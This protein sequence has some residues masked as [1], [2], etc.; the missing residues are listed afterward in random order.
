ML[1]KVPTN[2]KLIGRGGNLP[3]MCS[4][5]KCYPE[6]MFHLFF[7][8]RFAFGLWCWLATSLDL[9]IQF[10]SLEDIWSLCNGANSAQCR[11]VIKVAITHLAS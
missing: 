10:H 9:I 11:S 7:E 5:C 6:S 2:D 3:S 8:C 1:D 4:M